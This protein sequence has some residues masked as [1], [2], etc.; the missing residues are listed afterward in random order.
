MNSYTK[1]ELVNAMN[2][3]R[4]TFTGMERE[5]AADKILFSSRLESVEMGIDIGL[6]IARLRMKP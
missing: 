3:L 5:E 2:S 6:E 1:D 4:I